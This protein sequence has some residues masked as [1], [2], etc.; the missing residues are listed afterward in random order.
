[1]IKQMIHL[2]PSARPTFDTLLHTTRGPGRIFP[3]CFYSFL[4]NYVSSIN[5]L[6]SPSPFS[7]TS[8]HPQPSNNPSSTGTATHSVVPSTSSASTVKPT[9][10]AA[11]SGGGDAALPS[12]SDARIDRIWADYESVE[13]YIVPEADMEG[14]R[15]ADGDV[16]IDYGYG[17]GVTG[18]PM[19]D[20]LPVELYIPNRESSLKA[21]A[22]G[23]RQAAMEGNL[24]F[25]A[26][27]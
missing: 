14:V 23:S 19:V 12:D 9:T 20:I 5:D 26:S 18:K 2:D 22:A 3:E 6:P 21:G 7:P 13:A 16:K 27:S 1:M 4:H 8:A 25:V 11:A 17:S 10:I 24:H 15:E